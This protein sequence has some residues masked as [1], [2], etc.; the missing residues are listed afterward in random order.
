M[1]HAEFSKLS[2]HAPR[3]RESGTGR[4]EPLTRDGVGSSHWQQSRTVRGPSATG[5]A[6]LEEALTSKASSSPA[7]EDLPAFVCELE[8][9]PWRAARVLHLLILTATRTNE[10]RFTRVEEFDLDSRVWTIPGDRT[11]SGRSLRVP[12][13]KRAVEIVR[14]PLPKAKYGYLFP[15]CTEGR[16]LSNMAML[17]LLKRMSYCGITVHGFR[18][19]F[20]DWVAECTDY[21]DSLA[22]E[23]LAHVITS[24]TI[25]AYRRRDQLERRRLMMEDWGTYCSSG[26]MLEESMAP[27][28]PQTFAA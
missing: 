16:P 2:H 11:K 18:S 21:P 10:V 12:L 22:E 3:A 28:M 5:V 1:I 13:C 7:L 27:V 17:S 4:A 24:Q 8:L 14:N 20:R 15:G 9:R 25:A 19:T 6:A 23:V 26:R